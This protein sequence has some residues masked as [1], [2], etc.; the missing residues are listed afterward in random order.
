[1]FYESIKGDFE[2]KHGLIY[3]DNTFMKGAAGDLTIK[4][5][6]NLSEEILDYKMSYKP[7]ITSSLPAIAWIATL[8][9]LVLIGAVALDGVI[10]SKVVSEYKIEVTGPIDKPI[11]KIV[12]KKTQ[13]IKVGRSTPPEIIDTLPEETVV[14]IETLESSGIK[15]QKDIKEDG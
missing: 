8:N 5:N 1:M 15:E 6:T 7:N 12:D 11:V 3:T 10:T 2:I 4:G 14:P 13:N 9:P